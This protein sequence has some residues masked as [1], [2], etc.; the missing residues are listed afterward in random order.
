MFDNPDINNTSRGDSYPC[1]APYDTVL[2]DASNE[3][4]GE[5]PPDAD[6]IASRCRD[7]GH[8]R[9]NLALGLGAAAILAGG[10][11]VTM[12]LFRSRSTKN[13]GRRP[14]AGV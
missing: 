5:T 3:P 9:F 13:S 2:N 11:A 12:S 14:R 6:D 1:L 7:A 10:Y 8:E 4:G